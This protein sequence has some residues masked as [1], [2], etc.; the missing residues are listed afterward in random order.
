MIKELKMISQHY[1]TILQFAWPP[2][3]PGEGRGEVKDVA[4]TPPNPYPPSHS[5]K[6]QQHPPVE[7][8]GN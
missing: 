8:G 1:R 3:P 4:Y 6:Q 5:N 7:T 2:S